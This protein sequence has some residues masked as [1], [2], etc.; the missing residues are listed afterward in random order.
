MSEPKF[1]IHLWGGPCKEN[2]IHWL[3]KARQAG[4]KDSKFEKLW[5]EAINEERERCMKMLVHESRFKYAGILL[6]HGNLEQQPV[7]EKCK[8]LCCT[9]KNKAKQL[10]DFIKKWT[11]AEKVSDDYLI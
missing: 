8:I 11:M 9:D 4:I 1:K 2:F 6:E 10:G 3:N 7:C 5:F